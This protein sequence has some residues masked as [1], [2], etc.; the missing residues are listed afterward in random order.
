MVA[1][2]QETRGWIV[3]VT[4]IFYL[5]VVCV[6]TF[7]VGRHGIVGFIQQSDPLG[8]LTIRY[9]SPSVL[10]IIDL[11]VVL[12]GLGFVT[13]VIRAFRTLFAMG[14]EGVLPGRLARSTG[15]RRR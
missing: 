12:T 14:R 5:L 7:A 11:V 9:W 10:W 8:Y 1:S 6:E 4:G 15:N 13:A 3:I 2:S